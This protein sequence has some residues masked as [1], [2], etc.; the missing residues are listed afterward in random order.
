MKKLVAIIFPIIALVAWSLSLEVQMRTGGEVRLRITGYDPRDLLSGHYLRFAFSFAE[1]LSCPAD[2]SRTDTLCACLTESGADQGFFDSSELDSCPNIRAQCPLFLQGE[3]RGG[4]F[5]TG[6]ERYYI[7]EELAPAL[8][9]VPADA[10][11]MVRLSSDGRGIISR[12]MVGS[13]TIEDY[14][15]GAVKRRE[16]R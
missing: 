14:A 12:L 8:A 11:A 5:T 9:V 6:L 13:Q 4:R 1:K 2:A 3:C 15:K 7:P 16:M 10:S